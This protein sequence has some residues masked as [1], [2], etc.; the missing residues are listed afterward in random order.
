MATSIRTKLNMSLLTSSST[1]H[2]VFKSFHKT[3]VISIR[4]F[5]WPSDYN[6]SG[7]LRILWRNLVWI[8][9]WDVFGSPKSR[10]ESLVLIPLGVNYLHDFPSKVGKLYIE[11]DRKF[12]SGIKYIHY[13]RQCFEYNGRTPCKVDVCAYKLKNHWNS[14][15]TRVSSYT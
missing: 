12:I 5:F 6:E 7:R 9:F 11:N 4:V 14:C 3:F 13:E 2:N 15:N 8:C 1:H 10:V